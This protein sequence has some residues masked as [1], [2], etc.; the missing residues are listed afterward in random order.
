MKSYFVYLAPLAAPRVG[1]SGLPVPAVFEVRDETHAVV[2]QKDRWD[3]A[4]HEAS[5][6]NRTA[7]IEESGYVC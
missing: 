2:A 7:A 6:L 3:D 5:R 1:A 4:C